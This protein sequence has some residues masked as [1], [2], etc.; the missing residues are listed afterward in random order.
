MSG[1]QTHGSKIVYENKWNR[2]REDDVT[3]PAGQRTVY[4]VISAQHPIVYVVP[5]DQ[6][7]KFLLTK[8]FR[9]VLQQDTWEVVAGQTDG[10]D[11]MTAAR[12]E[13]L[14]ETGHSSDNM[15]QIARLAVDTGVCD[16]Y[17]DIV[18]AKNCVKVTDKLDETD[19]IEQAKAFSA[20]EIRKMIHTGEIICPHTI[21]GFYITND[22]L[23]DK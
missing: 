17:I 21:A 16:S 18:L 3:N 4:G 15:Q 5:V 1:W 23:K 12:R 20:E 7:G 9:Y 6:D 14:E 22:I 11:L 8:Q 19:G 10:E 13:L 2:V